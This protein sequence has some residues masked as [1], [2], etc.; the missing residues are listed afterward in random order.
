MKFYCYILYSAKL[1]KYY[2]GHTGDKLEERL[3]RHN[4]NHKGFTGKTND[5]QIVYQEKYPTK[6]EAYAREREIK[7]WKSR[8]KIEALSTVGQ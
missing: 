4:T 5:W 1:D 6:V 2:V 7:N 3:R 8:K